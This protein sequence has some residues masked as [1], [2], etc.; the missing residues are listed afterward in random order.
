VNREL[1]E[2]TIVRELAESVC[3]RVT[4][5]AIRALQAMTDCRVSGDDS[6]LENTWDEIC[7]QVQSEHSYAWDA[8]EQTIEA[9]L[10][11]FLDELPTFERDAVWLQTRQGADWDCTDADRRDANPVSNCDLVS[12]LIDEYVYAEADRW[13]NAQIKRYLDR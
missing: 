10:A 4:R 6:G 13:S 2:P 5:R 8:F 1:P 7:V 12:Y 11:G 3:Q 9:M